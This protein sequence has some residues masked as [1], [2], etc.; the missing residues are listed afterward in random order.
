MSKHSTEAAYDEQMAPLVA[1]LIEIAKREGIPLFVTA[2]ML[3]R[4]GEPIG[5]TT[6]IPSGQRELSGYDNRI[7]LCAG[8][9][10]G[11]SGFD[12]VSVLL[13]TRHHD[14]AEKAT[15][16][17]GD[18][19]VASTSSGDLYTTLSEQS[20]ATLNN[21]ENPWHPWELFKVTT[22]KGT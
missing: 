10:M 2:G 1:Q 9:T 8:I 21:G 3:D 17:A 14:E 15:W 18:K 19:V 20:A 4:N 7:E 13:I 16:K 11:H 12:T 22:D 5:C 6:K